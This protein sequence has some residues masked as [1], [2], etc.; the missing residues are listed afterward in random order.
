MGQYKVDAMNSQDFSLTFDGQKIGEL[1][2]EKWYSFSA[3]ILMTDGSQYQLEPTGFWESK[4][5]LKDDT[6][7]LL[8]FKLGWKGIILKTINE[9]EETYLLT[10]QGL[11]NKFILIDTDKEELLV[12][13]TDFKLRKS[14][15][16]CNIETTPKFDNLPNKEIFILTILH[17]IN[18]YRTRIVI[19]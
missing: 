2:Y 9:K 10:L 4:I 15:Y 17:C 14:N 6:K 11:G 8:E 19:G 13:E 7:T 16:N 5:E 12:A 1:I 3:K 18:Y